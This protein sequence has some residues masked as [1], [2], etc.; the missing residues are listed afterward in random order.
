MLLIAAVRTLVGTLLP[1]MPD[2]SL[3]VVERTRDSAHGD[4][5]S[6]VAMRLAKAERK[7]PR[8]MA[9]AIVDALPASPLVLKTEL[10]GGGFINFFLAPDALAR[11]IRRIQEKGQQPD[12]DI[13]ER[14]L[15]LARRLEA[16]SRTVH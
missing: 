11:E 16:L 15:A 5:T 1:E 3:V 2:A 4:Y 12:T 10:A 9:R 8:E 6:N 13:L 14:S 7:E